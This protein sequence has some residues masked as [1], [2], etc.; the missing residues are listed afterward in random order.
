MTTRYPIAAAATAIA[1]AA[2]LGGCGVFGKA[3]PK[4]TPTIGERRP[5]LGFEANVEADPALAGVAV[6]LP[7]AEA[8]AAWT[9][10]GGNASKS[11]GHLA[12][13]TAL[14]PAFTVSIGQ[15]ASK[16]DR[17]GAAPVVAEGRVYTVDTLGTVSAFDAATGAR[18]WS[19]KPGTDSKNRNSLFGG[20]VSYDG[21]RVY[22]TNGIGAVSALD[23]KTG[24]VIWS[25]R[26]GGPL[27]GAP[28]VAD[29]NVYVMSQDSQIFALKASDGTTQWNEAATLELAG[30]FGT[31]APAF[32]QG[33]V[34]AG[35]ASGDLNAYR[36]EN[37][38]Q[39]WN[40][41]LSR[42]SI[43]TSVSSLSDIDA[44]PVIDAG[45]VYAVGQG[46]RMVALELTT[47]QRLWELNIAGISTPW[48]A[49]EWLFVVTD[50]ARLM[51]IARATGRIRW[52]SQLA[53]YE[54]PDDKKGPISWNGPVLAGGR[55]ILTSSA[56]QMASVNPVDGT[57]L[58]TTKLNR[59]VSL[60]PVV[61]N[62]MLYILDDDG[63]LTAYRGA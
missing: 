59:P 13:G 10:P 32:G 42:T 18:V 3:G 12:L 39:L 7:P 37:G 8:N 36:Y 38:R 35:F 11:V 33:T 46:G 41:A 27:R 63:K 45:R 14:T 54:D 17:L 22:A 48:V 25:V 1:L 5:V 56:G 50:D 57:V 62:N 52:I 61:A 19:A 31:G 49:G 44:A 47:G 30:V 24:A 16:Y 29:G 21:G 4:I 58:S 43:S 9:Q 28:T 15:G 60:S 40:D 53:R 51:A 2:M 26:P 23:A 55:L 34:V 20:G 6:T